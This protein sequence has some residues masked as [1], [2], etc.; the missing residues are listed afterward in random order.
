MD[1]RAGASGSAGAMVI[2][3]ANVFDELLLKGH[4][5]DYEPACLPIPTAARPGS[6]EKLLVLCY[7]ASRGLALFHPQDEKI[8]A[9][10]EE[11]AEAKAYVAKHERSG[12]RNPELSWKKTR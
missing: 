12:T 9:T 2:R 3:A 10:I 5:E 8:L 1:D 6:L 11:V 4:D 7:R